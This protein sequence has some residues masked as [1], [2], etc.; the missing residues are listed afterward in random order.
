MAGDGRIRLFCALQL[1]GAA[2][3]EVG[4]WQ[5]RALRGAA[6]RVVPRGNLHLTL[7]FLGS[8]PAAE[9]DGIAEALRV[10]SALA[11]AEIELRPLRY[12]ET[13]GGRSGVGMIVLEDVSGAA[14]ALA[15][16]LQRR[17]EALGVYRRERRTWL[18]HLTVVRFRSPEGLRP[19]VANM[20]SVRV[21]RSALY[22]S[23]LGHGG[24]RYDA[25]ET[26]A[27]GG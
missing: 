12:R 5:E 17:L 9:L 18:P 8:R 6:G 21:V 16:D 1:P 19:E 2:L 14:T 24:A 26:A 3:D 22:R 4:E 7:A 15:G 10:A 20:R 11:P 23:S 13:R 27:L 25:L